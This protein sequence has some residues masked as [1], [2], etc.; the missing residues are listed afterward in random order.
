MNRERTYTG[1]VNRYARNVLRPF[2]SVGS[3]GF[4]SQ[5]GFEQTG[6]RSSI[7]SRYYLSMMLGYTQGKETNSL[8]EVLRYLSLAKKADGTA[9]DG[10]VYFVKVNDIRSKVR[11]YF[12]PEV[13][14]TLKE[15]GVNAEV[16]QGDRTLRDC[17][18]VGKQDV[19]G[20]M[21]GFYKFSWPASGSKMLPGAICEHF[22]A[23]A[24]K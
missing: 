3:Q 6:K 5:Y 15:L 23:M 21:V 22:T 8:A 13:A 1:A 4:R 12:F 24:L 2:R 9:P 11:E 19:M 17:L 14:A 20:A 7:G 18:P 16:I 10:S